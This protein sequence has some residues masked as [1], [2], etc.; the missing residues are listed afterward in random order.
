M[1]MLRNLT[2]AGRAELFSGVSSSCE[3]A[4]LEYIRQ[5]FPETNSLWLGREAAAPYRKEDFR[6]K[7]ESQVLFPN[8]FWRRR[9]LEHQALAHWHGPETGY[10]PADSPTSG[11]SSSRN[12]KDVYDFLSLR[13]VCRQMFVEA[14]DYLFR[15]GTLWWTVWNC[16]AVLVRDIVRCEEQADGASTPMVGGK[17]ASDDPT[18]CML[19]RYLGS[20]K[21]PEHEWREFV[22][23]RK[24]EGLLRWIGQF[25]RINIILQEESVNDILQMIQ[26]IAS[27][28]RVRPKIHLTVCGFKLY[29]DQDENY[30]GAYLPGGKN[31]ADLVLGQNWDAGGLPSPGA[32]GKRER[33]SI[34][35]LDQSAPPEYWALGESNYW[36]DAFKFCHIPFRADAWY[37]DDSIDLRGKLIF[38]VLK[39]TKTWYSEASE[40][41]S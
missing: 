27:S 29:F 12:P 38:Y 13:L 35:K 40:Y 26:S 34:K 30:W 18:A 11:N 20:E 1:H 32:K 5:L 8:A 10:P 17:V 36:L 37:E 39:D 24:K 33:L 19:G 6:P 16:E 4:G 2:A 3:D 15:H 28:S 9:H 25:R 23:R 21:V 41:R 7:T 31:V 14:S 22:R